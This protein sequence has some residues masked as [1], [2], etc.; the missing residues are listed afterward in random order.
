VAEHLVFAHCGVLAEVEADVFLILCAGGTCPY[1]KAVL[2]SGLYSDA[3][4][5]FVLDS[6]E[7][8]RMAR[9]SETY[10]MRIP[11]ERSVIHELHVSEN[12]PS[13]ERVIELER[14]V[15]DLLCIETAVSREV[16]VLEEKAV[17]CLLDR[18]S[19]IPGIDCHY[20]LRSWLRSC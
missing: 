12:L 1:G 17:H 3:E 19:L 9:V 10:I 8:Y 7:S 6:G 13:H 20:V 15:L 16:D 4:E 18:N 5:T 14:T 2:L 11:F